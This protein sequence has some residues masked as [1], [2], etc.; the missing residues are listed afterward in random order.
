MQ[1]CDSQLQKTIWN[2]KFPSS[3]LHSFPLLIPFTPLSSH[4]STEL[5]WKPKSFNHNTT[6]GRLTQIDVERTSR[7]LQHP[8]LLLLSLYHSLPH[9]EAYKK[10]NLEMMV[11]WWAA[12]KEN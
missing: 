12:Q 2:V 8:P 7:P 6:H 10:I 1:M 3:S 5:Q 11:P 9:T 4:A